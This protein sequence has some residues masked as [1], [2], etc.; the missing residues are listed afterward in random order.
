MKVTIKFACY[1]LIVYATLGASTVHAADDGIGFV[2][3]LG[4][5]NSGR[6][7]LGNSGVQPGAAGYA[8]PVPFGPMINLDG[9]FGQGRGYDTNYYRVNAFLPMH[10]VPA[11]SLAFA[12][13]NGG[14]TEDGKSVGSFGFGY[15]QYVKSLDRVFSGS[16]WFDYDDG[17]NDTYYQAGLN[18]SSMGKYLDLHINGTMIVGQDSNVII[19][20]LQDPAFFEGHNILQ[21]LVTVIE[22]AYSGV[23]AELGGPLPF[24]GRYGVSAYVGGYYLNSRE[25]EQTSGV[26][27]RVQSRFSDDAT[28]GV[29]YTS[30][31]VFGDNAYANVS[32]SFPPGRR[33]RWFRQRPVRERLADRVVR[34]GRIAARVRSE[35]QIIF[36]INPADNQPYFIV[37]VDPNKTIQ[38]T[39]AFENP[40]NTLEA[41]RNPN[42][43]MA[44][45]FRVIPRTDGTNFN[46]NMNGTFALS[47]RQR[48]LASSTQQTFTT[49]AGTFLLPGF[50]GPGSGPLI[51]NDSL[52]RS[53]VVQL[54]GTN[55][56]SGF[57]IDGNDA[58][59]NPIHT[60]IIGVNTS[61]FSITNNTFQDVVEGAVIANTGSGNGV[62]ISN[63]FNGNGILSNRAFALNNSNGATL[64][65]MM[66]SNTVTNHLGEDLDFDGILDAGEDVNPTNGVLDRGIAFQIVA[67]G[68]STINAT[69]DEDVNNN[70]ILDPSEDLNFNG[71]LDAG[72]DLNNNGFLDFG[73]DVNNNDVL[74]VLSISNNSAIGNG[75]GL[76]M[77]AQ[78]GSTINVSIVDN[79][80]NNNNDP[81]AGVNLTSD[82]STINLNAFANNQVNNNGGDGLLLTAQNTGVINSL[83]SEDLNNNGILDA[84]EDR[85]SNG[86]LD[87]GEDLNDNGILDPGED[88]NGNGILDGREDLNNNGILDPNE[89]LN[90]NGT[91]DLGITG[92]TI[93]GNTKSGIAAVANNGAINNLHIGGTVTL[94]PNT[95]I[96]GP[97]GVPDNVLTGNGTGVDSG[98]G[99]FLSTLAG[100]TITGSILNN[101][102][103]GNLQ[104][105]IEID[106]ISG[107]VTLSA[108]QFNN[109]Q[110]NIMSGISLTG[111]G[112][113]VDLGNVDSNNFDRIT[114]GQNGI[115]FDSTDVNILGTVTNS[116]FVVDTGTNANGSFGIGGT[117]DG[118]SLNLNIG[119]INPIQGNTFD[120]N[121][122]AAIGI[123]LAGA[124]TG[125]INIRNN[126]ITRTL[127]GA[128]PN[129]LGEGIHLRLRDTAQYN[130]ASVID[131]NVIGDL[132]NAAL[133][134]AS[135]GI[136]VNLVQDAQIADLLIGNIDG[137]NDNGNIISNNGGDGI[138]FVRQQN[139]VLSNVRIID[140]TI[141][142]NGDDGIDLTASNANTTDFYNIFD[143][144]IF[145]N[146]D[147]G[148]ALRVEADAD[149]DLD[150]MNNEIDLNGGD[151][152]QITEQI[153]NVTDSRSVLGTWTN[154]EITN[155]VTGHGIL[156]SGATGALVIGSAAGG[157]PALGNLIENNA[158]DGVE[159]NSA[160]TVTLGDNIIRLNGT[161]G[162]DFNPTSANTLN[163]FDNVITQNTGDGLEIVNNALEF[164]VVV[165]G[166]GNTI[167][168]NTGRGVD[169]LN[170]GAD[171]D[172]TITLNN[173]DITGNTLE[174]VY[175]VSTASIT[176]NQTDA[177]T[178]ALAS[179][180]DI[181]ADPF[182]DF[183]FDTNNVDGNGAGS[184]FA[185]TG[186]V[187]RVGTTEATTAFTDTGG[188][189]DT[190]SG[191]EASVTNNT[192]Q[193][194]FGADVY[195]E[196]FVSTVDPAAT[197]GT[198]DVATFTVTGFE[199]DPLARMDLIYT[200]NTTN[201]TDMNNLGAFFNNAEDVFKSRTAA[202]T[203]PGPF[204]I[205]TR[206]R[207]AQRQAVRNLTDTLIPVTPGGASD[208]FL[209][210][211]VGLST[212]RISVGST[213][214]PFLLDTAPYNDT[215]DANGE[216]FVGAVFGE[217]P[218][219]WGQF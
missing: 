111:T 1:S 198:W 52:V 46:L 73:E 151:G 91:I 27:I 37:H 142:L 116:S 47:G 139:G 216:P 77:T 113:T 219:G 51:V 55:Q 199:S 101:N 29:E 67:T 114:A 82:A 217:L 94:P 64:N 97:F 165:T 88:L 107:S 125:S 202:Q 144:D 187:F 207:N 5:D 189:A 182:L 133:G 212:F 22:N 31:G 145:S 147:D 118:G 84:S 38:G 124:A 170:Q 95:T 92:N 42:I 102:L 206:R 149:L 176:Q 23:D 81:V 143:N 167:T 172:T 175:I 160:G 45:I 184:A 65:L 96:I 17:H 66:Q 106:T 4:R 120:F 80:F 159:I 209:Y 59:A 109:I 26:R 123:E 208:T 154:N 188:F 164:P 180:G 68:G 19:K 6:V 131:A 171:A 204:T 15:R 36:A 153:N 168:L 85:N 136:A 13:L 117:V 132:A 14:V 62:L 54:N 89:D 71:I 63:T 205:G 201:S 70:G 190:R 93:T 49:V 100:G 76:E 177:S 127:A 69:G 20:R 122:D 112:G 152:I 108:I 61:G 72:E 86:I 18:F 213:A 40:F 163:L 186:L 90:G 9:V 150:L 87:V 21:N 44:D 16:G 2:D 174:G 32:L 121:S 211:G 41:A 141:T 157:N 75:T 161:G 53:S 137:D 194:N 162:V 135:H 115:F 50:T 179:D 156:I 58:L 11:E 185:G 34:N 105:G 60:G 173:N 214:A 74:D 39:G 10:I 8:V 169:I 215:P 103:E 138:N 7:V 24:I 155:S 30:D 119:G 218:F 203:D 12:S 178:V 158:L 110:N 210:S 56:V 166:T 193:G 200:G 183:N 25:D 191:I 195:A 35:S 128:V 126:T 104:D 43:A 28:V 140:N 130:A 134:N 33:T 146:T 57:I 98:N 79:I 48:L 197:A 3:T 148:I 78:A 181:F 99:I 192:M 129:F 196:S 83:L